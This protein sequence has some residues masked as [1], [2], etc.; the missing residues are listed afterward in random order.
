MGVIETIC[1]GGNK[2]TAVEMGVA[3]GKGLL[4]LCKAAAFFRDRMGMDIRVVG[5][6]TPPGCPPRKVS[7]TTRSYGR[8]AI[9][10]CRIWVSSVPSCLVSPT[11]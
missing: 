8:A 7:W 1:C 3:T 11:C 6:E 5:L 2:L 10:R 4:S 9:S